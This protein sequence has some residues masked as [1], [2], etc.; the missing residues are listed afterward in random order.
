MARQTSSIT[1]LV[2]A[3]A[4]LFSEQGYEATSVNQILEAVKL[5][6]GGLYH[7]ITNKRELLYLAIRQA[8]DLIESEVV[9]S[10]RYIPD[11]ELQLRTLTRRHVQLMLTHEGVM[12]MPSREVSALDP[13]HRQEILTLER[14]YAGF[15]RDIFERLQAEGK[16]K[17][18]NLTLATF[19]HFAM[20]LHVVHW[21]RP[22]GPLTPVQIADQI[23]ATS[24]SGVSE[25][26]TEV[27]GS[28]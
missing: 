15:V 10:V 26:A 12:I 3:A 2:T 14:R 19:N 22:H 6:K 27:A 8:W 1:D 28:N 21:Y 25:T 16:L 13:N 4:H 11:S 24:L 9:D 23:T 18:V 7:R 20:M 5:S 17:R